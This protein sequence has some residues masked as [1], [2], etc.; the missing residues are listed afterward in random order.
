MLAPRHWLRSELTYITMRSMEIQRVPACHYVHQLI[1]LIDRYKGLE[2]DEHYAMF[3]RIVEQSCAA[4]A[5]K[6]L[7]QRANTV[8][9]ATDVCMAFVEQDQG[10][11][12]LVGSPRA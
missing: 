1:Y 6:V 10:E 2:L 9:K 8:A 12:M 5:S 11:S 4:I 3:C 7:K